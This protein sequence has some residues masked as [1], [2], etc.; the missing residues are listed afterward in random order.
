MNLP[1]DA[2]EQPITVR[3]SERCDAL[4]NRQ[5][6]LAVAKELFALQGVEQTSMSEIA[7]V[8][9]V[10]QGTLYRH[11]ANKGRLCQALIRDDLDAF[12]TR[13]DAALAKPGEPRS[14]LARLETLLVDQIRLV[15]QHLP[16]LAAI[17][18]SG[19]PHGE[20][21]VR[22]P[23][24][25]WLRGHV[26]RLLASASVAGEVAVDLDVDYLADTILTVVA[27]R[28]VGLQRRELGYSLDRIIAGARQLFVERLRAHPAPSARQDHP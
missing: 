11:F 22:S 7:R 28:H 16:I 2:P 25:G 19:E 17:E 8:A 20:K 21:Q 12:M 24:S 4:A 13:T 6:L 9:G 14:S 23:W 10:G 26:A 15:D 3:R 27:P 1:A 5:R 18:A